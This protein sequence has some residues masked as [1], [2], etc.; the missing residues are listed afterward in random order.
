MA[1]VTLVLTLQ[2]EALRN[3]TQRSTRRK[4]LG[5][6]GRVGSVQRTSFESA[7]SL[8]RITTISYIAQAD[9]QPT[10][11]RCARNTAQA[12]ATLCSLVGAKRAAWRAVARKVRA[13]LWATS[14]PAPRLLAL[15]TCPRFFLIIFTSSTQHSSSSSLRNATI[16]TMSGMC[17]QKRVK[18]PK[19][20]W[21]HRKQAPPQIPNTTGIYASAARMYVLL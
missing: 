21:G 9:A 3:A 1:I 15:C 13:H 10:T 16:F 5:A 4:L 12:A 2:K 8:F 6:S 7:F 18:R 14:A 19:S 11:P 17:V 20:A